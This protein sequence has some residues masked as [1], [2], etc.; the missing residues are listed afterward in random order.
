MLRVFAE[1]PLLDCF[2]ARIGVRRLGVRRQLVP[3]LVCGP[4]NADLRFGQ[5]KGIV[6]LSLRRLEIT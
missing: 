3:F 2:G 6:I 1:G 4:L 5:F